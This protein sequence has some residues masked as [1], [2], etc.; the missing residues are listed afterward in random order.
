MADQTEAMPYIGSALLDAFQ[1]RINELKRF[2]EKT[3]VFQAQHD[4]DARALAAARTLADYL[5]VGQ[6]INK[7]TSNM[8][9]PYYLGKARHDLAQLR[10]AIAS[11]QAGSPLL[12]Y[13]YASLETGIGIPTAHFQRAHSI[14]DYQRVDDDIHV[15]ITNLRALQDNLHDTRPANKAHQA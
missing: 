7:Q 12:A 2:G 14:G 13:E 15:M 4:D 10:R 3:T 6:A 1:D 8:V 11:V 9:L 5:T